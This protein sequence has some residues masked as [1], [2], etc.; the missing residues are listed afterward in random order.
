MAETKETPVALILV[1]WLIV[2]IPAAWGVYNTVLNARK[3]FVAPV[4]TKTAG[5]ATPGGSGIAGPS[6]QKP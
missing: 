2:G 3:L 4:A 5:P 1:A 6:S